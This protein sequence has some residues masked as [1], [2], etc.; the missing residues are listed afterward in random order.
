MEHLYVEA[1]LAGNWDK[2]LELIKAHKDIIDF[3]K[4]P[5]CQLHDFCK[6]GDLSNVKDI[7]I[8][9]PHLYNDYYSLYSS[10]MYGHLHIAIY[11]FSLYTNADKTTLFTTYRNAKSV[12]R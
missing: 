4:I 11:L 3:D 2:Q 12:A 5:I 6:K 10:C 8:T 9:N 1:Y 7:L